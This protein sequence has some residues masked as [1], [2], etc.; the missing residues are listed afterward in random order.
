MPSVPPAASTDKAVEDGR[1]CPMILAAD[2]GGTNTRLALVEAQ[3]GR[4]RLVGAAR[5]PSRKHE[6]LEQI[7]AAFLATY[8]V[9]IDAACVG[10]AGPVREERAVVTNLPWAVDARELARQLS[11]PRV[12]LV[13]DVQANAWGIAALSATDF[14]AL[15]EGR[16]VPASTA[17][18]I[19]AGTGLGQAGLF[20]SGKEHVP[21]PSEGGHADFA[22]RNRLEMALLEH[23][24]AKFGTRVSYERV[25]SGP[26]LVNLYSFLRDTGRGEEPEWLAKKLAS[27]DA[28]AEV[29]SAAS[30]CA[31]ADRALE[32]FVS[33]Y[34]AAAGNV[35][36]HFMATAGLYIGGGI[37]P[38]I[39]HR[40]KGRNFLEAYLDKGRLSPLLAMIPVRIIVNDKT[41]LLGAARWAWRWMNSTSPD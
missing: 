38:K 7:I 17:A 5:F 26:G 30:S 25:L 10:V 22:P 16:A 32:L 21:I 13:N 14:V 1:R 24:Q 28:A 19:S 4:P 23:L 11:L 15:N 18:L 12:G 35:A 3:S 6:S 39:V 31:L 34:G 2:V 36:L 20:W 9:A 40:L 41:A 8:T 29:S 33:I 37:A 27:G